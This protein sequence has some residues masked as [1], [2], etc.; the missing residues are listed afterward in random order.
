[1]PRRLAVAGRRDYAIT[2]LGRQRDRYDIIPLKP[3]AQ[4][5][6][7]CSGN[8]ADEQ[9]QLRHVLAAWCRQKDGARDMRRLLPVVNALGKNVV[10]VDWSGE[11]CGTQG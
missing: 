4:W 8:F 5:N 10:P 6:R 2:G 9:R 11:A 7:S 3:L 1:M